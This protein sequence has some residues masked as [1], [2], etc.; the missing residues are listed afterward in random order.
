MLKFGLHPLNTVFSILALKN[1]HL[2]KFTKI[3]R[4]KI[5]VLEK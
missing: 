3:K 1:E 4:K 5:Y 2:R